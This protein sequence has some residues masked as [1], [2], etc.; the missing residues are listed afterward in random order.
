MNS[1]PLSDYPLLCKPFQTNINSSCVTGSTDSNRVG[2][3]G[4]D[5]G[6]QEQRLPHYLP[7]WILILTLFPTSPVH[8]G[9]TT[10]LL[11]TPCGP[12]TI[13]PNPPDRTLIVRYI[14]Q[15]SND[16]HQH[17][18]ENYSRIFK[19]YCASPPLFQRLYLSL[20]E[21]LSFYFLIFLFTF[22]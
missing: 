6:E 19:H 12:L 15:S 2:D 9:H 1:T 11:N 20:H 18:S 3:K 5:T 10:A 21:F 22:F 16:D 17:P 13:T 4:S 7:R 14:S 8:E